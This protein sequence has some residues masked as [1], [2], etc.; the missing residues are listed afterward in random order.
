MINRSMVKYLDDLT[1][2]FSIPLYWE[3][4]PGGWIGIF[5]PEDIVGSGRD[6]SEALRDASEQLAAWGSHDAA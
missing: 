5:G 2:R 3:R 4:G 6:F 1:A